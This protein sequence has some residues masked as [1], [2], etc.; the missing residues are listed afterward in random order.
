MERPSADGVDCHF[1]SV[2]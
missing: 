2:L 1:N